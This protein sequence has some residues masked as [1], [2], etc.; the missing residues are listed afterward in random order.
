MLPDPP[1]HYVFSSDG[2]MSHTR[3][4]SVTSAGRRVAALIAIA[5]IVL[6]SACTADVASLEKDQD[7][8]GLVT[9]LTQSDDATT[10]VAAAEALGRMHRPESVDQLVQELGDASPT[11]RKTVAAV[12]AMFPADDGL[13]PLLA[14]MADIDHG[15]REAALRTIVG[16]RDDRAVLPLLRLAAGGKDDGMRQ[17][18]THAV[19]ELLAGFRSS[20]SAAPSPT[21]AA[22]AAW[23]AL[24]GEGVQR[25]GLAGGGRAGLPLYPTARHPAVIRTGRAGP[26][27][28]EAGGRGGRT[29]GTKRTVVAEIL[30][31][32][33]AVSA[34][35]ARPHDVRS[36]RLLLRDLLKDRPQSLPRLQ[37]IVADRGYGGLQN[38]ITI[39]NGLT[40]DIK[41]KA[42]GTVGFKPIGPL[43]R[44]EHVFAQLGR[45]RRLARCYEQT[46]QSAKAWLAVASVGYML[47]RV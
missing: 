45:W 15:V 30:G 28:H 1:R 17:D 31:L 33:I 44:I 47:G 10:R 40:V 13:M 11:V 2:P 43:W 4:S 35:S 12:L 3:V 24:R 18:A 8:P 23:R 25:Q 37:A 6:I 34:E 14:V 20:I 41:R 38:F 27:F 26:T 9:L 22:G 21:W 19:D 32:P 39:R 42:P 29:I 7:V 36:G 16:Y 5:V 46:E